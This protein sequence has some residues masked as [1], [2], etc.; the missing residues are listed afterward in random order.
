MDASTAALGDR[1]VRPFR[2]GPLPSESQ[3]IAARATT[4][5]W[6]DDALVRSG[7]TA[8]LGRWFT[9]RLDSARWY[10]REHPD[11]AV[12]FVDVPAGDAAQWL[13]RDHPT[14]RNFASEPEHEYFLPASIADRAVPL[15]A[16]AQPVTAPSPM[17]FDPFGDAASRGYL[18]NVAG[19]NDPAL[20]KL[21][22]HD[23]FRRNV[24]PA[25]DALA[26]QSTIRPADL[27]KTHEILF[28]DVYPWA[29]QDRATLAP[30]LA[31]GKGG[32]FDLFAHPADIRRALDYA[33]DLGNDRSAI[34]SRP[35]EVLGYLAFAHPFLDGNGRTIMTAHADLTRRAGFHIDWGPIGKTEY[36]TALTEELRKPSGQL[37]RLLIPL[38]VS[39]PLPTAERAAE[40]ARDPGLNP[41]PSSGP[42][43]G[44]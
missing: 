16:R 39:G 35:G 25:L 19:T 18:R 36:L 29:G 17:A 5:D 40:L 4:A 33:L 28:R 27:L 34:A 1:T 20:V 24:L 3:E 14:A 26:Q 8:A 41:R 10:T 31:I 9:S 42:S 2:V 30:D 15:G 21:L 38:I 32:R 23:S 6:L 44:P 11:H 13:A 7:S 37:D 22:E 43:P 12:R